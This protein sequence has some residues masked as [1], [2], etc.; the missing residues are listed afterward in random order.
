MFLCVLGC[1]EKNPLKHVQQLVQT[2]HLELF[3]SIKQ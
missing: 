1:R 2:W 3:N